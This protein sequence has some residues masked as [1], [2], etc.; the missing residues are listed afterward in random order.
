M[1]RA[2]TADACC[3]MLRP[4]APAPRAHPYVPPGFGGSAACRGG[5]C[6]GLC[7]AQRRR[8][9]PPSAGSP[10]RRSPPA[11]HTPPASVSAPCSCSRRPELP[12]AGLLWRHASIG[13]ADGGG[14]PVCAVQRAPVR[15]SDDCR[16]RR[17][18]RRSRR[19]CKNAGDAEMCVLGAAARCANCTGRSEPV[20]IWRLG[21]PWGPEMR[22]RRPGSP[23]PPKHC[24]GAAPYR[25]C[26]L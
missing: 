17:L 9:A 21:W 7:W 1:R 22:R 18:C 20:W 15:L 2:V 16:P 14:R 4:L 25:P 8:A 11:G 12:A 5:H 19:L 23:A 3:T 26:A 6:R 10:P 24:K 13:C